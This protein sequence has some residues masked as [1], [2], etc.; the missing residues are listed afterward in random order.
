MCY[1]LSYEL[2]T[3]PQGQELCL[4]VFETP[5]LTQCRVL[6]P[7]M[8]D[9]LSV[10]YMIHKQ[11]RERMNGKDFPQQACLVTLHAKKLFLSLLLHLTPFYQQLGETKGI[12]T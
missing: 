1:R 11:I 4:I 9:T 3:E 12:V 5:H 10:A 2:Q 7:G 6:D 8:A